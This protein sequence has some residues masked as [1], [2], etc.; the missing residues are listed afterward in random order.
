M[1]GAVELVSEIVG[2]A[3]EPAAKGLREWVQLQ[4]LRRQST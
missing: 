4:P 1:R 3:E 2:E